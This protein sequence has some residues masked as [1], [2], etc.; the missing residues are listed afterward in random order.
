MIADLI[1]IDAS[2]LALWQK[3]DAVSTFI[4]PCNSFHLKNATVDKKRLTAFDYKLKAA[5]KRWLN[6]PQQAG[7]EILYMSHQTGGMN[8]MPINTVADASQIVHGLRLLISPSV[9]PLSERLLQSVVRWRL[10]RAAMPSEVAEYLNGSMHGDFANESS[11]ICSTWTR[12]W[13]ATTW[14][15]TT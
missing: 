14:I 4:L 11:D 15:K 10:R 9:G 12:L 7:A 5:A 1:K 8:L 3:I 13:A 6:L 2:L